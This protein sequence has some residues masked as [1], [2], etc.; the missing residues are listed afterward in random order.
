[1]PRTKKEQEDANT[2]KIITS[3]N[4]DVRIILIKLADR[5]HNMRTLQYKSLEK[6][7]HPYKQI[8]LKKVK[9]QGE[10]VFHHHVQNKHFEVNHYPNQDISIQN[11]LLIHNDSHQDQLYHDIANP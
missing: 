3:L 9:M 6:N 10:F 5:L 2:R 8:L 7:L 11:I 1:M 4:K